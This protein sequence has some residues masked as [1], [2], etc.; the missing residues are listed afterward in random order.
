MEKVTAWLSNG[1]NDIYLKNSFVETNKDSR[2]VINNVSIFWRYKNIHQDNREVILTDS[3]G[4]QTVLQFGMGYWTFD[5]ISE[6]FATEGVILKKNKHNNTCRI[7][8]EK[9][10]INLGNFV[11]LLGF[12]KDKVILRK[13]LTDSG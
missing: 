11:L 2:I 7:P 9:Y 8:C 10:E 6:R 1:Q 13:V 5:M 4:S 3:G 12:K